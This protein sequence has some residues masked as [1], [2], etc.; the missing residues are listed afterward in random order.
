MDEDFG[1]PMSPAEAEEGVAFAE[2]VVQLDDTSFDAEMKG[3]HAFVLLHAPWC[4]ACISFKP[5][6][7]TVAKTCAGQKDIMV[8]AVDA[9][10]NSMLAERFGVEAF[11]T[12]LLLKATGEIAP[13]EDERTTEGVIS[14]L[15][16]QLRKNIA[17][18]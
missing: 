7:N 9:T 3:K 1:S 12:I 13:Y 2:E 16:G 6:F 4:H 14:F 5:V 17:A 11:P 10:A 8:V 18:L 15:N